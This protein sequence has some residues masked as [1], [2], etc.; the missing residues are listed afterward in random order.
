MTTKL[1][2][3]IRKRQKNENLDGYGWELTIFENEK[4]ISKQGAFGGEFQAKEAFYDYCN[5]RLSDGYNEITI[6]TN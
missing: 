4:E 3:Q 1:T 2:Y 5:D 6:T